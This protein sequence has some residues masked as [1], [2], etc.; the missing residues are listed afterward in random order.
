MQKQQVEFE[1][2]GRVDYKIAWD[3]QQKLLNAI[4]A[5]K[6]AHKGQKPGTYPQKHHLLLCDHPHVYTL[7]RSGTVENLLLTEAEM[8]SQGIQY[9]PINRGGDI[10]YHGPG[11]VVG[12]PLLDLELFF[13]DIHKYVR[14]LEEV[15]ILTLKDYGLDGCRIKD[16]TG[17]WLGGENGEKLRKICAIGVHLSRWVTL[18]GFA[19]NVETDLTYFNHIVPC[20]IVDADKTVTSLSQELGRTVSRDETIPLIK[21]HFE[22]VF[23]CALV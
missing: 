15:I 10:T 6:L 23:D 2:L 11:Q 4:V 7:G 5:Q 22:A 8:E 13:T 1:E 17:V 18:H 12:Y 20:G 21:K 3:Y 14:Y 9:Y 19:F 16:Y